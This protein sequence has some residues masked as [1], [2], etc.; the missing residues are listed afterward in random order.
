MVRPRWQD[1]PEDERVP[2][3]GQAPVCR[4]RCSTLTLALAL[5]L[6]LALTLALILGASARHATSN[7]NR[8]PFR[9]P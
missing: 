9:D 5:T 7:P 4:R 8:D 6:T 3:Q 2:D 1:A